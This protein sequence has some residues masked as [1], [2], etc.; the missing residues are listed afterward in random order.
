LSQIHEQLVADA[1]K[2]CHIRKAIE[3]DEPSLKEA[4]NS[5]N[6]D[7]WEAAIVEELESLREA[8]TWDVVEAPREAKLFPSRF[9]IKVKRNSDGTL[10]RRKARL[11]ILGNLQRPFVDFYDAYAPVADFVVVRVVLSTAWSKHWVVHQLDVK[12]AF[13]NGYI[14]E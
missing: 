6:R 8:G 10:E 11:F 9:V 2:A 1:E 5:S 14:D 4:L 7:L 12:S 3:L 13:L